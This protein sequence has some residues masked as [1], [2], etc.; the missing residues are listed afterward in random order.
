MKKLL[1]ILTTSSAVFL[2]TAGVM[3]ANKKN[4]KSDGL[5]LNYNNKMTKKEHTIRGDVLTD[6]G[7]Y[8]DNGQVRIQQIPQTVK[9]ISAQLPE[10]ITSLKGAFQTRVNDITWTVTWDTSR[11]TN[12]NSMFYNTTWFNNPEIL[13]WDT[14]N[15]TDMGE[16]FAYSKR[17]N[18]DLSSWNV[19]KV[20]NFKKMFYNAKEYNNGSKPLRWND[21]LK[22]VVNMEAMFQGASNFEHSLNDWKLE[23]EVN[24]KNFGLSEDRHPKWKEKLVKPSSPISSSNSSSS[25]SLNERSD[26]N[27]INRN[28]STPTNSN[29]IS[30][31]PN[32]DLS[33][34]TTNNENISES[35]MSNN[36]L[37]IPI[38]SEKKSKNPKNNENTNY[39]IPSKLNTIISKAN[40][41]NAGIIAGSVL[42][43]FTILTTTAGLGYYYRKNLKNLYLKSA[44]KIKPSLLKSKDN[45]KDFYV[46]SIDK[47][48]NLYLKSKNKI[49]DKIAKIRS[50]K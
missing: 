35:S 28:S 38:S 33:S 20:K 1:T 5:T 16:M 44:D 41:P 46:K 23:T 49:K 14:S 48:K 6:I 36:M 10:L 11:I 37:E 50:K 15:V 3:I 29:T 13:K 34:N 21:K 8:W 32:N 47:T 40:S 25:N 42:G 12:M 30:T 9:T 7:Y 31:N 45:I 26:D 27:Q 39:K 4:N 19:L 18:L 2:I 17:F 24:N 43:S 22:S